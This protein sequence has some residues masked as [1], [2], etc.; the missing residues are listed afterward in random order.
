MSEQLE[1]KIEEVERQRRELETAI[2][3]V[4]EASA[5]GLDRQGIFALAVENAV[6]ACE[7][8]AGRGAPLDGTMLEE[9][10]AGDAGARPR[11]RARGRRAQLARESQSTADARRCPGPPSADGAHGIAISLKARLG[12]TGRPRSTSA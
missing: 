7:A 6:Q 9:V 5:S 10:T 12:T 4:G 1:A 3:R 2:R 8:D 11:R